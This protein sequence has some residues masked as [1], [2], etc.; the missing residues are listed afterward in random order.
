MEA[1]DLPYYFGQISREEAEA[2]LKNNGSDGTFLLRRSGASV[3][4]LTLSV[5]HD[6]RARHYSIDRLLDGMFAIEG[7]RAFSSPRALCDAYSRPYPGM[8]C[9]LRK[10][11]LRQEGTSPR[12]S[13]FEDVG[14][15]MMRD[16]VQKKHGLEGAEAERMIKHQRAELETMIVK[17][18]HEKMPWFHGEI[19]REEAAERLA[20]KGKGNGRFLLRQRKSGF[21]ISLWYKKKDYHYTID[22][23]KAD[24]LSIP[25]G[26]KFDTLCQLV[27]H[28][29]TKDDGLLCA[30]AEA[31]IVP[32]YTDY[33]GNQL[34]EQNHQPS[35]KNWFSSSF[36]NTLRK[37]MAVGTKLA[38]QLLNLPHR[39]HST[40]NVYGQAAKP[41]ETDVFESPYNDPDE[42]RT[43]ELNPN[44]LTLNTDIELGAGNFATVV[45]GILRMR[46][47]EVRAAVKVLK[48]ANNQELL[49]EELM[50]EAQL[51][52][53]LDHPYI[54]RM[55]G[56]CDNNKTLML[57]MELA[58]LGPLNKFLRTQREIMTSS[59][60]ALLLFQVAQGMCYLEE[61]NFVHRDLAARNVLLVTECYAKISDFGLSKALNAENVYEARSVGKWP[62]KWYAPECIDFFR[63]TS[64]SDVWSFAITMWE[65]FSYG[66]KPYRG[67]RG[68]EVHDFLQKGNRL[69]S[70]LGCPPEAYSL[71]LDCWK[72]QSDVR[73]PFQQVR[74]RMELLMAGLEAGLN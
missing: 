1:V 41:T 47:R 8:C 20:V 10:P 34:Q 11:I 33:Y 56:V 14:E 60:I 25:E 66:E 39:M 27:E 43:I 71:M 58:P 52:H 6:G 4:G 15:Q 54:V 22:R 67:M 29:S 9:E 68:S 17:D 12:A 3:G 30:L 44:A 2:L 42:L 13:Q 49:R 46:S 24:R 26:K 61:R 57:V 38:A 16:Y 35:R 55:F 45:P 5:L 62:V 31:C 23:D 53:Q 51:M 59:G 63:F 74:Q 32:G 50:R 73:P 69:S 28:Y 37:N 19:N 36:S 65:A 18:L 40:E 48:Q 21:V 7:G 64:K 70:P 72:Y